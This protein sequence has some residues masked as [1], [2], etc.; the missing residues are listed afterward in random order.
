MATIREVS[1]KIRDHLTQQRARATYDSIGGSCRYLDPRG[2][3]CAVGCLIPE[4]KYDASFEGAT[5]QG[6]YEGAQR[7]RN[8]LGEAYGLN[9]SL[10]GDA[11]KVL[12]DWQQYHD[13]GDYAEWIKYD[14]DYPSA[15][16]S[17]ARM[18]DSIMQRYGV[19]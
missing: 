8:L 17:P 12:R 5:I 6:E 18:H 14:A 19:A 10:Y 16:V 2:N 11:L 13:S 3:K 1:E 9:M 4:G 15:W 7:L